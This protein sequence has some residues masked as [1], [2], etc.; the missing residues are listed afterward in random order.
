[1]H[2]GCSAFRC[3]ST[4]FCLVIPIDVEFRR[5]YCPKQ[6]PIKDSFQYKK[7]TMRKLWI[8]V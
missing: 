5:S 2:D 7:Y 4:S 8:T 1:M 6:Y 3:L